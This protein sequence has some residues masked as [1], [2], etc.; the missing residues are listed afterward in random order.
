MGDLVQRAT[1]WIVSRDTGMSSKAIWA[2][3]MGAEPEW[4]CGPADP[5]DLG[6]CLRLLALIPE[7]KPRM[8]EMA[9]YGGEWAA[10][11]PHWDELAAMM[12]DEV[13]IAWEKG[14]NAPKTFDRMQ[15]I[16]YG[17]AL[18]AGE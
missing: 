4:N 8:G 11:I 14:R 1:Q 6:R 16:R 12:A 3:M 9:A 10:L 2:H 5:A 13:G 7:W 18:G 15:A 17:K